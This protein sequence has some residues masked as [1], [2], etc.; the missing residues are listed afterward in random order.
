[1]R[2]L[3]QLHWM[4]SGAGQARAPLEK[5]L[6]FFQTPATTSQ[7]QPVDA[8][9]FQTLFQILIFGLSNGSALAL[10]A[11]GVTLIYSISVV[12]KEYN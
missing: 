1:M 7:K 10:N 4:A 5:H 12:C 9:P 3:T 2:N 6:P 11:S 8:H